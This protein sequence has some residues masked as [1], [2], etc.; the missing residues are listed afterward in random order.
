M[1]IVRPYKEEDAAA[2]GDCFYEG[3]FTCPV[4]QN[5][6]ML[7]RDYAQILVEKCNFTYVA[8][9]EDHQVVGFICGEYNKNFSKTLAAQHETKR[10]YW[11][12]CKKFL[13]FYLKDINCQRHSGNSLMLLSVSH[14]K[15]IRK[16]LGNAIWSLSPYHPE[17]ITEKAWGPH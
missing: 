7:L 13:K 8:E 17:R 11:F 1:F 9:T 2:C 3:F 4:D 14:R 15:G 16:P 6:R 10:H 12:W 5:D